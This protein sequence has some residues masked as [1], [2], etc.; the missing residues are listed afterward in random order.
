MCLCL[1]AIVRASD[2]GPFSRGQVFPGRVPAG[3]FDLLPMIACQKRVVDPRER[4]VPVGERP[5]GVGGPVFVGR[6]ESRRGG[7]PPDRGR[8]ET[9][10]GLHDS[11]RRVRRWMPDGEADRRERPRASAAR[12]FPVAPAGRPS[13]RRCYRTAPLRNLV[14]SCGSA[15]GCTHAAHERREPLTGE[16]VKGEYAAMI[17]GL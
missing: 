16:S 3:S 2:C 14:A 11:P 10:R 9:G 5:A 7:R 1:L 13:T 8:T 17:V 4:A 6:W 12:Q 15:P